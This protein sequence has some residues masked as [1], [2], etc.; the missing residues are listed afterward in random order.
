MVLTQPATLDQN[1]PWGRCLDQ[2]SPKPYG[3]IWV[4]DPAIAGPMERAICVP[5]RPEK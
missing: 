4:A 1:K 3:L 2:P 5:K